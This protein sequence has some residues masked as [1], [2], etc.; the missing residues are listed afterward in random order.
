MTE[1]KTN[2]KREDRINLSS[3]DLSFTVKPKEFKEYLSEKLAIT[4]EIYKTNYIFVNAWNEWAEGTVLE[5]DKANGYSYLEAI[6]EV[7]CKKNSK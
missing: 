2:I 6:Q 5:P 4:K 3:S 7:L 1:I